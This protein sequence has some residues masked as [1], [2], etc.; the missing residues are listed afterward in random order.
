MAMIVVPV[1]VRVIMPMPAGVSVM[2][3]VGVVFQQPCADEVHGQP[4]DGDADGLVESDGDRVGQ[5][6]RA[7]PANQQRHHRQHDG[8]GKRRQVTQFA[9]AESEARIPRMAPG[10]SV[11]Q[12]RNQH[13]ACMRGHM[14]AVGHQRHRS[15]ERPGDDLHQHHA[16]GQRDDQPH[17]ALV[18]AMARAQEYVVVAGGGKGVMRGHDGFSC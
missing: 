8:A 9:G 18:A 6:D 12:R 7:F 3:M 10:V 17:L 13:G 4:D 1:P 16:G 11:G 5:P 15:V 14:P 2:V